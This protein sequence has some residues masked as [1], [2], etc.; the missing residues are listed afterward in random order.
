MSDVRTGV[1]RYRSAGTPAGHAHHDR[2]LVSRYASGDAYEGELEQARQLVEHCA[3]C[4]AL[5]ADIRTLSASLAV[6]LAPT[7]QRDF[8]ITTEQ[9]EQLRGSRLD[10]LFRRLAA[11]GLAPARPLAGVALSL[12]LALAVVGAA[13]PT[14]TINDVS[15]EQNERLTEDFGPMMGENPAAGD[16]RSAEDPLKAPSEPEP[17]AAGEVPGEAPPDRPDAAPE[18]THGTV[19]GQGDGSFAEPKDLPAAVADLQATSTTRTVLI[20]AGLGL[21]LLSLGALALVVVAR[22]RLHDPLLR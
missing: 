8:R 19:Y 3:E 7:R 21:A 22:R 13:L 5:A 11:P 2:V 14:P 10:R 16:P 1:N 20:L 17:G 4:A 6:S 15:L 9:A 12:G 18:A